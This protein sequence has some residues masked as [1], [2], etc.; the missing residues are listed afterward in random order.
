V[1][2]KSL[3][4]SG[5]QDGCK[6]EGLVESYVRRTE[7]PRV[8][9]SLSHIS[10]QLEEERSAPSREVHL[11]RWGSTQRMC[12]EPVEGDPPDHRQVGGCVVLTG[13]RVI[14]A[15]HDIELTMQMVFHAPVAADHRH[16]PPRWKT[17]RHHEIMRFGLGLASLLR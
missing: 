17:V 6:K 16:H 7:P 1:T 13:P 2:Q 4:P 8:C 12:L 11:A 14:L 10:K 5:G 9:L 3:R 15:E